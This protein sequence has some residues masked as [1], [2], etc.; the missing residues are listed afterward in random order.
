MRLFADDTVIYFTVE[1]LD[2]GTTMK[3][4]GSGR[5][6]G[7]RVQHL[8]VPGGGGDNYRESNKLSVHVT[9]SYPGSCHPC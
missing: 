6:N 4:N 7:T 1:D 2:D 5:V 8:E 3:D 9:W